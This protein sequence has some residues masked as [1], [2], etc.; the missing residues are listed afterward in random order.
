MADAPDLDKLRTDLKKTQDDVTALT[1]K[2]AAMQSAIRAGEA[3]AAEIAQSAEVYAQS[4]PPMQAEL[5]DDAKV[6]AKKQPAAED[7]IKNRKDALV[8]ASSDFDKVLETQAK[9]AD[10][11]ADAAAKAAS[12]VGEA[13]Q[14][15]QDKQSAFA[16]LKQLPRAAAARLKELKTLLNLA[17]KAENDED[18]VAFW[19]YVSEA[20]AM[21]KGIAVPAADAYRAQ[22]VAAQSTVEDAKSALSGK[23]AEADKAAAAASAARKAYEAARAS[24]RAGLLKAL[25]DVKAPGGN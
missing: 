7:G 5:A 20:G 24:R 2:A 1:A 9:A 18:A 14:D 25:R 17:A 6:I 3:R 23:R 13:A 10:T 16:T 8:K 11:A 22:L 21:A 12:A 15:L 4:R 19:F